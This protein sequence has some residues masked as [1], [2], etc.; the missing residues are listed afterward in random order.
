MVSKDSHSG[1]GQ[2]RDRFDKIEIQPQLLKDAMTALESVIHEKE[3]AL[4]QQQYELATELRKR[5][6]RLRER[7]SK[8]ETN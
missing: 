7:I 4:R 8:L 3:Q 5:E 6:A 1:K 2:D